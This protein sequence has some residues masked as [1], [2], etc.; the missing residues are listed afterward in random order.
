MINEASFGLSILP[1]SDLAG[2]CTVFPTWRFA[3]HLPELDW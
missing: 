3:G 2:T 1:V